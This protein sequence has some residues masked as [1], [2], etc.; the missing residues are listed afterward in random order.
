MKKSTVLIICFL[1]FF[2]INVSCQK[3]EKIKTYYENG[4]LK[5]I[6]K[7]SNGKQTGL[8]KFYHQ[9][10]QLKKTGNFLNG[11]ETGEWKKYYDNGQLERIGEFIDGKHTGEWKNY[12]NSGQ[13]ERIGEFSGNNIT[14]EWKYYFENGKLEKTGSF[15]NRQRTGKWKSFH[16]NGQLYTIRVYDSG[17]LM[18]IVSCFDGKGNSLDKGTLMNGNG[19]VKTYDINSKLSQEYEVANG[20]KK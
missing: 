5:E 10:G 11:K 9:N 14:G 15:S 6:G 18:N 12:Y 7:I 16:K 1:Q 3:P 13:L 2:I 8:W 4:N 17:K 19:T 20:K